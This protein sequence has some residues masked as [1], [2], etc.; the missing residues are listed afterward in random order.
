MQV[1]FLHS[2]VLTG[3][4]LIF[5]FLG[6]CDQWVMQNALDSDW[7]KKPSSYTIWSKAGWV[8]RQSSVKKPCHDRWC[9]NHHHY[10]I[11][12]LGG[13][14]RRWEGQAELLCF[15]SRIF[16]DCSTSVFLVDGLCAK[17]F[18][19][20]NWYC[21][22]FQMWISN[23][24]LYFAVFSIS[25]VHVCGSNLKI[26][27]SLSYYSNISSHLLSVHQ[28]LPPS[29]YTQVPIIHVCGQNFL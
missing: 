16:Q 27:F 5:L 4:P 12:P 23:S 6:Q 7:V 21:P 19:F 26:V 14:G 10:S 18:H 25:N 11:E 22:A 17:G 20:C 3:L 28:S 29:S 24:K 1:P 13:K 8:D 2:Q 9:P 15:S